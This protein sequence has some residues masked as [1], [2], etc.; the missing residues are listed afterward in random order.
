MAPA[1]TCA[2]VVQVYALI[3]WVVRES[4]YFKSSEALALTDG[5]VKN[6]NS[7]ADS[8]G[9]RI[10]FTDAFLAQLESNQGA[11][12]A[13]TIMKGYGHSSYASSTSIAS[14]ADAL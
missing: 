13:A 2:F 11:A 5:P 3:N 9:T 12:A 1:A 4:H 8:I 7:A 10:V 6:G 14:R